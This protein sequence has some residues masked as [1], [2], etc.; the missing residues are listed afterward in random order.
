[1]AKVLRQNG[2]SVEMPETVIEEFD[3]PEPG[4]LVARFKCYVGGYTG[5]KYDELAITIKVP[6]EDKY[7]AMPFT[8]NDGF[9]YD[10][11][12]RRPKKRSRKKP[13]DGFEFVDDEL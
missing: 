13:T 12:V 6:K 5:A 8:D 1:M 11:E 3:E 7:K 2:Q 10:V 9:I 4:G